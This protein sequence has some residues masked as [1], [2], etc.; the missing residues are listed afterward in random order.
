MSLRRRAPGSGRTALLA[1]LL[2]VPLALISGCTSRG[3]TTVPKTIGSRPPIRVTSFDFPESRVLAEVYA[4]ALQR[5]GYPVV[6]ILDLGPREVVE[7]AL[8]QHLVDLVPEYQGSVL[9]FL[10]RTSPAAAGLPAALAP[11]GLVAA[12]PAPAQDRNGFAVTTETARR[13]GLSRISDLRPLARG[14]ILGGPPECPQRPY[15]LP[16]LTSRY[17]LSFRSFAVIPTRAGTAEALLSGEIGVGMLETTDSHL[18]DGRLVGTPHRRPAPSA[19]GERRPGAPAPG[20][21]R[22]RPAAGRGPRRSLGGADDPGRDRSESAGGDRR[23]RPGAG[24]RRVAG[25]PP[26]V[27]G[28]G[29]LRQVAGPYAASRNARYAAVSAGC[30]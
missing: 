9:R 20:S 11:R 16:G 23:G 12:H 15:C 8:E 4:A 13:H 18:A 24:R 19:G 22:V 28:C 1:V 27:T 26:T 6:R 5:R 25:R 17:G 29:W 2:A 30:W 21:R 14:L 7:P 10:A 3:T